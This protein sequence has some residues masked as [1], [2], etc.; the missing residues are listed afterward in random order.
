MAAKESAMRDTLLK[1]IE[2]FLAKMVQTV[3]YYEELLLEE[4]RDINAY[5]SELL[6]LPEESRK[7][8]YEIQAKLQIKKIHAEIDE[9]KQKKSEIPSRVFDLTKRIVPESDTQYKVAAQQVDEIMAAQRTTLVSAIN[10]LLAGILQMTSKQRVFSLSTDMKEKEDILAR[11]LETLSNNTIARIEHV[12]NPKLLPPPVDMINPPEKEV[13][14]EGTSAPGMIFILFI[15]LC[16][17]YLPIG[18]ICLVNLFGA[19]QVKAIISTLEALRPRAEWIVTIISALP[20]LSS[21]IF[22]NLICTMLCNKTYYAKRPIWGSLLLTFIQVASLVSLPVGEYYL[23]RGFIKRWATSTYGLVYLF[24]IYLFTTVLVGFCSSVYRKSADGMGS[25]VHFLFSG[26]R[27]ICFA[28]ILYLFVLV[29]ATAGLIVKTHFL[30][31]P[32]TI[33]NTAAELFEQLGR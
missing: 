5:L 19:C 21:M 29:T 10:L 2:S 30:K 32:T 26:A 4:E 13:I 22:L 1:K 28:A 18:L 9:L 16:F 7:R 20:L 25:V 14:V 11:R 12:Q 24:F 27:T 6:S 23:L 33:I 17:V 3:R 31:T 8:E 15:S